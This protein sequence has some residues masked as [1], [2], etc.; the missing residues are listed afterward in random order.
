[1][2]GASGVTISAG[3]VILSGLPEPA[4]SFYCVA[5]DYSSQT[6]RGLMQVTNDGKLQAYS[7]N[8]S[9]LSS[10][11]YNFVYISKH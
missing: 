7:A 3:T 5:Y 1:M 2:N 8:R 11:V 9:S 4:V 10:D 6:V